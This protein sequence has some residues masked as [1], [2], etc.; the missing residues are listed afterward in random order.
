MADSWDAHRA[1]I[2]Q[3]YIQENR[4]LKYIA[5]FMTSKGF[6]KTKSQ[7]ETQFKKWGL[8]KK[9]TVPRNANWDFI[10]RRVEKRKR[11]HGK[12]SEV[13]IDEETIPREKVRKLQY[14][15]TFVSTAARFSGYGAPS[16]KTPEGVVVR[17]P[18]SIARLAGQ[19]W[20]GG[21]SLAWSPSLPWLQ[22]TKLLHV[23]QNRDLPALSSVISIPLSSEVS[24]QPDVE[25]DELIHLENAFPLEIRSK[26]LH[27]D[28]D[29]RMKAMLSMFMPEEYE[30][31]HQLTQTNRL[32]T[33]LYMLSNSLQ[34]YDELHSF[35]EYNDR[36]LAMIRT[37]GWHKGCQFK[38]LLA[39]QEPTV[40]AIVEKI[41]SSAVCEVD[42]EVMKL[43][44]EAGMDPNSLVD[45]EIGLRTPLQVAA[46]VTDS[47]GAEMAELLISRKADIQLIQSGDS[48]LRMAIGYRNGWVIEVLLRH[49]V[50]VDIQC[51]AAA[52]SKVDANLFEKLLASFADIKR[53]GYNEL[54][55]NVK[56]PLF[57]AISA[58]KEKLI[59]VL[60]RH[61]V[62]VDIL[63]LAE[64][65]RTVDA[66]LFE[67]LL[68]SCPDVTGL[69]YNADIKFPTQRGNITLLGAAAKSGRL[70]IIETILRVCPGLVNPRE[71]EATGGADYVS[72]I[73]AAIA[74]NHMEALKALLDAGV[75]INF[76]NGCEEPPLEQALA[77]DNFRAYEILVESGVTI[78]RPLSYQKLRVLMRFISGEEDCV[79][80]MTQLIG[81]SARVSHNVTEWSGE[82]LA[83]AINNN[84]LLVIG[85]LLDFGA[86]VVATKVNYTWKKT[87]QYLDTRG[88]LQAILDENGD[89]IL[90]TVLMMQNWDLAQWLLI[91]APL[92]Q[93]ERLYSG[94]TPLC[95]AASSKQPELV[96]LMLIYGAKVTDRVLCMAINRMEEDAICGESA[97]DEAL[98]VLRLLLS[99]FTGPAPNVIVMATR[100]YS[101]NLS[102]CDSTRQDTNVL[103]LLLSEGVEP[104]GTLGEVVAGDL[105]DP[106]Q[107]QSALELVVWDRNRL[108]L[109]ILTQPHYHWGA[110]AL[111]RCLAVACTVSGEDFV[112]SILQRNPR[113]NEYVHTDFEYGNV[114]FS[115]ALQ[116][117]V[118]EQK[119]SVVRKL[120]GFADTD[121]NCAAKGHRGRTA[122][123]HAV[124]KGNL[125]LITMLLNHDAD[126]TSPPAEN[127]GATALQ[128]AAIKGYLPIARRL[129]DLGA[130]VNAA[131][132]DIEGRMALEGA[133]EHGRVDMVHMLLEEGAWILGDAGEKQYK[134]AVSLAR[135][136]GHYAV[137]RM[138]ERFK[139]RAEQVHGHIS[140]IAVDG[141]GEV[142]EEEHSMI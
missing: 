113:M 103:Q 36:L 97:S 19:A 79:R 63:C 54:R 7:Y 107:P 119:V 12:E 99:G 131:G 115:T 120:L 2:E 126:V 58:N 23:N 8:R 75:D 32:S 122:L 22:F 4:T 49:N 108:A 72:P 127:R 123:Q 139:S 40:E 102:L 91:R 80:S 98:E 18:P 141:G 92:L 38:I 83:E 105:N 16:P 121:I 13:V 66:N 52:T 46:T 117:A 118:R 125:E 56:S 112:D 78:T 140:S 24:V 87:A 68:K 30:G 62:V 94:H 11:L 106:V 111:G 90:L 31:Q 28:T 93:D 110:Q 136:N 5:E 3:L 89:N 70:E 43:I 133:A 134:N 114:N 104:T 35:W 20:S 34:P 132:A 9:Q 42:I 39:S 44:L 85:L 88:A 55:G 61:N 41:F 116:I 128:L 76:V 10:A 129:L 137:A 77:R 86:T 57:S 109:D 130:D 135:K 81:E 29:S 1:E 26:L 96:R 74:N 14:G 53:L 47:R 25:K 48:A 21:L 100:I 45:S 37:F 27:M 17:T 51:L 101:H 82:V 138:L 67:T 124:E 33:E 59:E 73:S 6:R 71:L 69:I 50:V 84:D 64:A 65:T 142:Y 15:K 60:L 95:S